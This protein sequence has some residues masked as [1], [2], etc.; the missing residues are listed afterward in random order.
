M[1]RRR[2]LQ[3]GDVITVDLPSYSRG[4][5]QTGIRPAIVVGLPILLGKPRYPMLVIVPMTTTTGP[6]SGQSP[7]LYPPLQA[8]DGGLTKPCVALRTGL[9]RKPRLTR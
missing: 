1:R 3:P 4:H 8:G 9:L 7:D 2:P 5:E 6:W